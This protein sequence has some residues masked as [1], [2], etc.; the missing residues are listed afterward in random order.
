MTRPHR[1]PAALAAALALAA[2]ATAG[3]ALAAAGQPEDRSGTSSYLVMLDMQQYRGAEG[4]LPQQARDRVAAAT[5]TAVQRLTTRGV[6]VEHE[7]SALGGYAA[8]LTRAEAARLG[9]DPAVASV[10]P[11]GAVS[12]SDTQQDAT[13]GLDRVD[14]RT[15]PLDGSYGHTAAGVGVDSYIVDTGIRSDHEEFT[16]RVA[17][18]YNTVRGRN[19]TEDCNG[20]GTHVAGTVGG[21]TYGVAKETTLIPVRV[22]N[23]RGS[24]TWSGVVAGM[25]W[26]A[27]NADG[28]SV[29]NLS[30]GGAAS[31]AVDD[32]VARMV[33]A[34]VTVAVA[35]GNDG[36]DACGS[37]PARAEAALTV[38]A[39]DSGD[40]RPSW[41]NW[42]SCLDLFAP[43]ASI[44]SAWHTSTTA[45][46]TISGTSMAS[47]H[48]AGA[49][50]L[51]LESNP[52]AE[53]GQVNDAVTGAATGGVVQ[54]SG[55][56]SPELLLYTPE[57]Q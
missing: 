30:L 6:V 57:L 42:G 20:H 24:G 39:T 37:S 23:C 38:G 35:A 1:R 16:G 33:A 55:A 12:I 26:V 15:L 47:P 46:N 7:Y 10:S 11:D 53:P 43:G 4:V 36:A 31:S 22:L 28:P 45:T 13:W 21:A 52:G 56:G 32:A 49:A 3:P 8:Q 9:R 44:T 19:T 25:D 54:G 27:A 34:G 29:A 2:T 50:A 51:Y 41:S 14:Q 5:A 48:V 17:P 18:G 40:D